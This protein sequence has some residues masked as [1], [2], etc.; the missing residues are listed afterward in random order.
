MLFCRDTKREVGIGTIYYSSVL[1]FT[2]KDELISPN[3]SLM[4]CFPFLVL[5]HTYFRIHI[6]E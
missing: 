4:I 3:K 1:K 5:I 2:W 6:R